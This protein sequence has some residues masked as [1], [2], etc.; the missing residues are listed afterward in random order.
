MKVWCYVLCM[1][2]LMSALE[3]GITG[4]PGGIY[5]V[6][7]VNLAL[8]FLGTLMAVLTGHR[9]DRRKAESTS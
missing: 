1:F 3:I 9:P 7:G 2:A 6:G 4:E 8:G 5:V